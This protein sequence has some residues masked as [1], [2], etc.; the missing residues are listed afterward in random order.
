MCL[1]ACLGWED[2]GNEQ[3]PM[4]MCGIRCGRKRGGSCQ[5]VDSLLDYTEPV[6]SGN[7]NKNSKA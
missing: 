6:K 5:V 1:K 2:F 3:R 7:T 4:G